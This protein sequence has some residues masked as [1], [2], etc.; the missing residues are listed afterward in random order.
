MRQGQSQQCLYRLQ[1]LQNDFRVMEIK[2]T[3][4]IKKMMYAGLEDNVS[5]L[6]SRQRDLVSEMKSELESCKWISDL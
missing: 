5:E 4:M 3:M 1:S 2:M 6:L